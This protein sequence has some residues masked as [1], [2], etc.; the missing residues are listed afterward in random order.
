[1]AAVKNMSVPGSN[2]AA[3]QSLGL[4]DQLQQQL[5]DELEKRR[6]AQGAAGGFNAMGPATQSLF[7]N[8][9]GFSGGMNG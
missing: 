7:A 6:K 3:A 8:S 2:G 9:G 5:D 1:M 4:G